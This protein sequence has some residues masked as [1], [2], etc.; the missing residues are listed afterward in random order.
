MGNTLPT[1][2]GA[3]ISAT[4]ANLYGEEG[5]YILVKTD[6]DNLN[7]MSVGKDLWW[8]YVED[9]VEF[10]VLFEGVPN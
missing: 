5:E 4:A 6:E 3:V 2:K 10:E 1:N 7:W 8:F 9:I